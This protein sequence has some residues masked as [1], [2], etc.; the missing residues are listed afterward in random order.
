MIRRIL[1]GHKSRDKLSEKEA[2]RIRDAAYAAACTGR[3]E[4]PDVRG[5][6]HIHVADIQRE[7]AQ[8]SYQTELLSALGAAELC[9][10]SSAGETLVNVTDALAIA[11]DRAILSHD[12]PQSIGTALRDIGQE[13][14]DSG[15][16]VMT[17]PPGWMEFE[18]VRGLASFL[19]VRIAAARRFVAGPAP[20]DPAHPGLHVTVNSRTHGVKI[21][22][23][24]A[25]FFNQHAAFGSTLSS[26]VSC[27][28]HPGIYYFGATGPALGGTR[29]ETTEEPIPPNTTIHLVNL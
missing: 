18:F 1:F 26:P 23:S 11:G 28:L 9:I 12:H 20:P 7:V 15:L 27:H 29:W 22:C 24:P 17:W 10:G 6:E 3:L 13:L 21:L 8:Y 25:F 5:A 19:K 14:K 2:S 4:L 16:R